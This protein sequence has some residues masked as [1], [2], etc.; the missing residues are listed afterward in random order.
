MAHPTWQLPI[1]HLAPGPHS[2]MAHPPPVHAANVQ[3][4]LAPSQVRLQPPSQESM[5]QWLP[6]PQVG[7]EHPPPVQ[8]PMWQVALSPEHS[9]LQAPEQLDIVHLAL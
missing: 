9:N 7:I 4:E 1:V 5:S 6:A 8:A 2:L 3:T